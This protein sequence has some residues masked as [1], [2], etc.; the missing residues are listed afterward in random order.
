MKYEDIKDDIKN[1]FK[2]N[3]VKD[4]LLSQKIAQIAL[5]IIFTGSAVSVII[6]V[7]MYGKTISDL[8]M[9]SLTI[10]IPS[11][12]AL[13]IV[14]NW[15]K[16]RKILKPVPCR[17]SDDDVDSFVLSASQKFV[18]QFEDVLFANCLYLSFNIPDDPKYFCRN[19]SN[20]QKEIY[21]K[22]CEDKKHRTSLFT[23]QALAIKD[24]IM[25][26]NR[27]D[28]DIMTGECCTSMKELLLSNLQKISFGETFEQKF[29]QIDEERFD[30]NEPFVGSADNLFQEI[31]KYGL[32]NNISHVKSFCYM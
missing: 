13:I 31:K 11:V 28:I 8:L 25:T 4:L 19:C 29:L 16:N 14:E 20:S 27:A 21:C 10:A 2:E 7:I 1:Y 15:E 18:S 26:I 32:V 22:I 9:I 12:A 6:A 30:L 24:G 5:W 23:V 3:Y 17:L